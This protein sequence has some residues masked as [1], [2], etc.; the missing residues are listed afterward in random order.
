MQDPVWGATENQVEMGDPTISIGRGSDYGR[1]PMMSSRSLETLT[2]I[3]ALLLIH[4][5]AT[6]RGNGASAHRVGST[7]PSQTLRRCPGSPFEF[8]RSCDLDCVYRPRDRE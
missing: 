1:L 3:A 7:K 5:G 8:F 6:A 4:E 2:L